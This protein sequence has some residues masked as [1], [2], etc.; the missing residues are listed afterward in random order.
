MTEYRP[1]DT[2]FN[3][4]VMPPLFSAA[5]GADGYKLD[6]HRQYPNKTEIVVSNFTPRSS[7][8]G[9]SHVVLFGLQM[10]VIRYLIQFWNTTFF[11]RPKAEAIEEFASYINAYLG[12]N[13]VGIAHMEALHDLGFLPIRI[14]AL[15]EGTVYPL[16][17]PGFIMYNTNPAFY[18]LT[19][20]LETIIS[21]E[22]WGM[23]TSATT[24]KLYYNLLKDYAME[25]V[26]DASFVRFQGHDFSFR[27]M[28]GS[29]AA[30]KS[31]IAHLTSFYGTDTIAALQTATNYYKADIK[32][33][34]VGVSVP[35]TEHSV[36]CAGGMENEVETFRRLIED[37]YPTGI[38]SIVSDTWDYWSV[39]NPKGG[40][41]HTL[42]DK[43]MAR[44]GKVVVRPDT[45]DP[46][47]IVC[48]EAYPLAEI[49]PAKL[50]EALD[51]GYKVVRHKDKYFTIVLGKAQGLYLTRIPD[52]EVTPELKGSIQCLYE[53]FGGTITPKG[54]KLLDEHIGL[55]YG[56]S[57]TLE[58]AHNICEQ[59]KIMGF[60]SINIVFGIGSFTYAYVTRDTDGYAI[61]ATWVRIDGKDYAIF[62]SPKTGD[63]TKKSAKGLTA[64]YRDA[65]G[66]FYL[67][68]E[69]TWDEVN[70]CE[71]KEV[72][73]DGNL[74]GE[75]SLDEVRAVL[76]TY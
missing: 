58:R 68:D 21:A 11:K 2:F 1:Y 12:P 56:D 38:I 37:L 20:F 34:I 35:A 54:Y 39:L 10:V 4:Y 5:L 62:K 70:N 65:N 27:G 16:K 33:G 73:L 43:I 59:L 22:V 25:T 41:L 63:G 32:K 36:M 50:Q 6:H 55:I 57:I 51:K 24:A 29:S 64:V 18:W 42:K 9:G 74:T 3:P 75:T 14:L 52:E 47:R 23:C 48:G 61:K 45:G 71:Y 26:G 60:A 19:N 17:V 46:V 49:L 8:R 28:F 66:E 72:F 53:L 13:Q 15:P 7:R 31:D 30:V 67:K 44:K 40:I 69:A 76:D